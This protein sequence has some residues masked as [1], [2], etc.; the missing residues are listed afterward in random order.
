MPIPEIPSKLG[1]IGCVVF[2]RE[3]KSTVTPGGVAAC[4]DCGLLA[5]RTVSG[6][7]RQRASRQRILVFFFPR[8]TKWNLFCTLFPR[9]MDFPF[10]MA[11]YR[12]NPLSKQR[13]IIL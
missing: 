12:H 5:C 13:L 9:N 4:N 6:T 3:P 11:K 1:G 2:S 10:Q 7:I 8:K